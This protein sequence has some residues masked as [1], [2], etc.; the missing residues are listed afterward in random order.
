MNTAY[1]NPVRATLGSINSVKPIDRLGGEQGAMRVIRVWRSYNMPKL[2]SLRARI[3][4]D[5]I[6]RGV[7]AAWREAGA[8]VRVS[9]LDADERE[10]TDP[11]YVVPTG[12]R[13]SAARDA[14]IKAMDAAASAYHRALECG[15]AV[16]VAQDL[17]PDVRLMRAD[18]TMNMSTLLRVVN[19][20][21]RT[22]RHHDVYESACEAM[23]ALR[24]K[25][26][27]WA[28]FI[29]VIDA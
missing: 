21:D 19:D 16:D 1:D 17:L 4:F 7:L 3:E 14:F 15:V 2:R 5:D 13:E 22:P 24:A 25:G 23:R 28:R 26:G 10:L 9:D 11:W 12:F 6:S 27:Q 8:E 29:D 18:V 20:R